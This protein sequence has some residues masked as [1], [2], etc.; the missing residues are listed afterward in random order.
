SLQVVATSTV[1]ILIIICWHRKILP[2]KGYAAA[3]PNVDSSTRG[4]LPIQSYRPSSA[5]I[6]SRRLPTLLRFFPPC[7]KPA[8]P[9]AAAHCRPLPLSQRAPAS[10]LLGD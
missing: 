10:A 5:T 1:R 7:W 3:I 9:R 8:P 2:G 6:Y 4:K